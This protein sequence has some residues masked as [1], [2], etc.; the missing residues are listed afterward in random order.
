MKA[1]EI[2]DMGEQELDA[3]LMDLAE[4]LFNLRFQLKAGQL[5]NPKRILQVKRD[6]ARIKTFKRQKTLA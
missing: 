4:T 2:K 6:I 3:K 1:A 5:E